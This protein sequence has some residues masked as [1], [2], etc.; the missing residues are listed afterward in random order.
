[1]CRK[2]QKG[3]VGVKKAVKTV[4]SLILACV[5]CIG[6]SM[7]VF[8]ATKAGDIDGDGTVTLDD[9]L[10]AL[11]AAI[12][13]DVLSAAKTKIADMDGDG[14]VTTSDARKILLAALEI[15][16][17]IDMRQHYLDIGFPES[18]VTSL[19]RLTKNTPSGSLF[20]LTR[21]LSGATP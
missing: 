14:K 1:M 16:P 2:N 10:L 7:P 12:G 20:R 15:E 5:I 6:V 18:Y 13:L 3:V 21:G 19:L 8:A 17:E 4:I 11:R 9:A